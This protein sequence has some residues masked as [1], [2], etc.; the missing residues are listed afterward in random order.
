MD[1]TVGQKVS[2]S[3]GRT[4]K[5]DA[6]DGVVDGHKCVYCG[7]DHSNHQGVALMIGKVGAYR[8]TRIGLKYYNCLQC[9]QEKRTEQV[10]CYQAPDKVYALA[11]AKGLVIS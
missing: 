7:H 3:K 9:A 11:A 1:I 2:R 8:R 10:V 4:K 6:W 5:F